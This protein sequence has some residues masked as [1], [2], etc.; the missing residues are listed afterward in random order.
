MIQKVI[1]ELGEAQHR[2]WHQSSQRGWALLA[3]FL[4]KLV[5]IVILGIYSNNVHNQI[6][7]GGDDLQTAHR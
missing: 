6:E 7:T 4:M 3:D 2:L 5:M 1:A